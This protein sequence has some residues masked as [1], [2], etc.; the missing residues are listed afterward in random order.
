MATATQKSLTDDHTTLGVLTSYYN[1]LVGQGVHCRQKFSLQNFAIRETEH[2]N[3]VLFVALTDTGLAIS[4]ETTWTTWSN[5]SSRVIN[6]VNSVRIPLDDPFSFEKLYQHAQVALSFAHDDFPTNTTG[7]HIVLVNS[8]RPYGRRRVFEK[9]VREILDAELA[10]GYQLYSIPNA[11]NP[12]LHYAKWAMMKFE[13]IISRRDVHLVI[14]D[15][16]LYPGTEHQAA[17]PN[18][19]DELS[20]FFAAGYQKR[21]VARVCYADHV[22]AQCPNVDFFVTPGKHFRQQLETGIREGLKHWINR[23]LK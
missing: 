13:A 1:Y 12:R 14:F 5:V 8:D 10:D 15:A 11:P 20:K 3:D 2:G 22:S 21:T 7:S 9:H 4:G 6:Y 16:N 19:A 18:V 23:A 17:T